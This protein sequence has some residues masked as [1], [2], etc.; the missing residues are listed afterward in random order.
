MASIYKSHLQELPV[1]IQEADKVTQEHGW[2]PAP[3]ASLSFRADLD[4]KPEITFCRKYLEL[5]PS[6]PIIL[7][8]TAFVPS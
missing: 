4:T 5:S 3:L 7:L 6:L 8:T 1:F 2:S